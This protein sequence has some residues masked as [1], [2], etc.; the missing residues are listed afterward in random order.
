M[1]TRFS[2]CTHAQ[3][4]REMADSINDLFD[5]LSRTWDSIVPAEGLPN[6]HRLPERLHEALFAPGGVFDKLTNGGT[7][8]LP[9]PASWLESNPDPPAVVATPPASSSFR[10]PLV[11]VRDAAAHLA[12]HPYPYAFATAS[13]ATGATWYYSPKTLRPLFALV[14]PASVLPAPKNRPARVLPSTKNRVAAEARKECALVLGAD[15]V[16]GREIALDLEKR[17]WVVI[18]TVSDPDEVDRLEREGRG[19][20]KVLVLD[21]REV[22]RFFLSFLFE[23]RKEKLTSGTR[24]S[25]SVV[26]VRVSLPEVPLD[27]PV[28]SVP[29]PHVGRPVLAPSARAQPHG[30]RR[31]AR[32]LGPDD[33]SNPAR[34]SRARAGQERSHGTHRDVRPRLEGRLAAL[35]ERE[36]ETGRA[37]RGSPPPSCVPF[38]R[39]VS[40]NRDGR[41]DNFGSRLLASLFVFWLMPSKKTVPSISSNVSLPFLA[42]S[43][44]VA[45]SLESMFHSLRRELD[46]ATPR[47]NLKLS[48]LQVG[49]FDC[50]SSSAAASC[51]TSSKPLP[52]RLSSLYAPALAR[53]TATTTTAAATNPRPSSSDRS[54]PNA[55]AGAPSRR[56]TPLSRLT[57]KVSLLVVHPLHASPVSVVGTSSWIYYYVGSCSFVFGNHR[58]IDSVLV[59]RDWMLERYESAVCLWHK[60][61]R[62]RRRGHQ[63]QQ[64][65]ARGGGGGEGGGAVRDIPSSLRPG[66]ASAAK[67]SCSPSQVPTEDGF[68]VPNAAAAA[69]S[70][71]RKPTSEASSS[72]YATESSGGGSSTTSNSGAEEEFGTSSFEDLGGG[73]RDGQQG[74]RGGGGG[75]GD[76][77]V[78]MTGSFV[79][80]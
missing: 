40:Q 51:S 75:R 27:R 9:V 21:P 65:I 37:H 69:D 18:A 3:R 79:N 13:I 52:I 56:R 19:W 4:S 43:S 45:Q 15:T 17:G 71:R 59:L 61:Y 7:V 66:G 80:V 53:R 74:R 36:R 35:E 49:S 73:G 55:N 26:F 72:S 5:A 25:A 63:Q 1:K 54:N 68:F 39:L 38:S 33:K 23:K 10:S 46:L 12:R 48:I 64:T 8:P 42:L 14:V 32:A 47:P 30:R 2:F 22:R 41:A 60:N 29:P 20:I 50:P 16:A 24:A 11:L 28:P 34:G 70:R 67:T 77:S 6:L 58:A 76:D 31:R 78:Y 57:R 62:L 44:T